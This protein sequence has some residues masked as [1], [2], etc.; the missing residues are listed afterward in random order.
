MDSLQNQ[1]GQD[2]GMQA[3]GEGPADRRPNML[4]SIQTYLEKLQEIMQNP[5]VLLP[6][7]SYPPSQGVSDVPDSLLTWFACWQHTSQHESSTP[8]SLNQQILHSAINQFRA[9]TMTHPTVATHGG[10]GHLKHSCP[11]SITRTM[12]QG[13]RAD[14]HVGIMHKYVKHTDAATCCSA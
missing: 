12:A 7:L 1:A 4:A 14:R 2:P 11:V 5:S 13:I 6:G 8:S 10:E 3:F 9:L